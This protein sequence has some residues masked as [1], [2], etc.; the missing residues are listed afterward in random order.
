MVKTIRTNTD[1]RVL[2]HNK[3]ISFAFMSNNTIIRYQLFERS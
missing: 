1:E 2:T 3:L